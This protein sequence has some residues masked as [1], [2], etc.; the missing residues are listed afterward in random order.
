MNSIF[1]AV[2]TCEDG[3]LDTLWTLDKPVAFEFCPAPPEDPTAET[4]EVPAALASVNAEVT[5]D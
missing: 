3:H 1:I 5:I 4:Q 2:K